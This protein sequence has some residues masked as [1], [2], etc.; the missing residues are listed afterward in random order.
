[1]LPEGKKQTL[2]MISLL[3]VEWEVQGMINCDII[4]GGGGS[5]LRK[6]Q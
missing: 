5:K 6:I 3:K 4:K 1:M 2:I